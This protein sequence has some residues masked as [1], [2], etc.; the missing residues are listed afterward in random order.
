[1]A[2]KTLGTNATNSLTA[3]I[4]GTNDLITADLAAISVALKSDPPYWNGAVQGST[5]PRLN[6]AYV[7]NGILIIPNRGQLVL[8][9]GD[10]V[11][12]D[13]TTGWPIVVSADAAASGPYTH[14]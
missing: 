11:C 12:Y 10:Y 2:L 1:M 13:A 4:V 14:S 8:R 9:N 7:K 5:R 6:Q 3:F